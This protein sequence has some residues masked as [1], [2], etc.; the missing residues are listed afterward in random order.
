MAKVT[1][2]ELISCLLKNGGNQ[3][4]TA[5]ELGLSAPTV[6]HRLKLKHTQA[7]LQKTRQRILENSINSLISMNNKAVERLENLLDDENAFVRLQ[8]ISKIFQYTKDY[9]TV[10]KNEKRLDELEAKQK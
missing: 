3:N 2:E 9:M 8:A 4:A 10:E 7:L 6:C 5:I 1:D